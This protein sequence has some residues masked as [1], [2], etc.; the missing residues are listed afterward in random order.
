MVLGFKRQFAPFVEDGTKTHTV[1][2]GNRWKVGMRADCW[3]D[4]RKPTTWLIGRFEVV[5][6]DTIDITAGDSVPLR[7]SINGERLQL[8]D[9]EALLWHDGFREPG[10]GSSKQAAAF[11]RGKLPLHGQLIHWRHE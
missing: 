6:V 8:W 10:Q 9:V 3:G 5:K 4:H 2:P 11:W 1:R 7:V